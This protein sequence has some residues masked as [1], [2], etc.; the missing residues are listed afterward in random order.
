MTKITY[1]HPYTLQVFSVVL[2]DLPDQDCKKN[3]PQ[4]FVMSCR[5][6]DIPYQQYEKN[7]STRFNIGTLKKT[8]IL[9]FLEND[10]EKLAFTFGLVSN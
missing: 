6:L 10:F 2:L 4:V 7:Y 1:I 3:V 8:A 9:Q 5:P